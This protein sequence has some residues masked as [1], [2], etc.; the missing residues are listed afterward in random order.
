[1]CYHSGITL[2]VS[3]MMLVEGQWDDV[4]DLYVRDGSG[5]RVMVKGLR[6]WRA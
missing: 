1:M 6:V 2:R 5:W 4:Y 3:P